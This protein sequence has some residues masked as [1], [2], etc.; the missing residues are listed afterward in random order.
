MID[1]CPSAEVK[2]P[3]TMTKLRRKWMRTWR[4]TLGRLRLIVMNRQGAPEVCTLCE[5]YVCLTGDSRGIARLQPRI[6][7]KG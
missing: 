6:R 4:R 5:D 2:D 3:W 7:G 1:P